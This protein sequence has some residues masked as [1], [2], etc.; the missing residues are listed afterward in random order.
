MPGLQPG[1]EVLLGQR[2]QLG[3]S[4]RQARLLGGGAQG[5]QQAGERVRDRRVSPVEGGTRGGEDVVR[6]HVGVVEAGRDA[7]VGEFRAP[8]AQPRRQREQGLMLCAGD[9][10]GGTDHSFRGRIGEQ[11]LEPAGGAARTQVGEPEGE[12]VAGVPRQ[13]ELQPAVRGQHDVPRGDVSG[14]RVTLAQRGA[15]VTGQRPGPVH[16][17]RD[18]G[19]EP[20]RVPGRER[21]K[22]RRLE[23]GG[24]RAGLE[25]HGPA[26]DRDPGDDRVRPRPAKCRAGTRQP[27]AGALG[28]DPVLRRGEPQRVPPRRNAL[29]GLWRLDVSELHKYQSSSFRTTSAPCPA[30]P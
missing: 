24:R 21:H 1:P 12:Q 15:A 30:P 27:G 2:G 9:A 8:L 22:Q 5:D 10:L 16:V 6:V 19:G 4:R 13:A 17:D 29:D 28:A 14:S 3:C 20:A 26:A 25:P 7:K 11:P 23:A 18:R